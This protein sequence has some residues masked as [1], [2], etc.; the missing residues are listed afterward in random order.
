MEDFAD[1]LIKYIKNTGS[2]QKEIERKTGVSLSTINDI[3][4]RKK[5][6]TERTIKKLRQG[7]DLNKSIVNE[8][9]DYH[10]SVNWGPEGN[11]AA[12]IYENEPEIKQRQRIADAEKMLV[13]IESLPDDQR[14]ALTLI[15][16]LIAS[17][18]K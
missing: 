15:I 2:S 5:S 7:L 6:P 17:A 16:D 1:T 12:A 4:L 13:K 14:K 18:Q 8:V 11:K 9:I 10:K 3:V